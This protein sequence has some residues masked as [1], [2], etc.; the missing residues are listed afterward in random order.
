MS[1]IPLDDR[2]IA[3]EGIMVAAEFM[4][5]CLV[6]CEPDPQK[7]RA[8]LNLPIGEALAILAAREEDVS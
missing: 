8:L 3:I 2:G 4:L 7:R 6:K 1:E 5:E